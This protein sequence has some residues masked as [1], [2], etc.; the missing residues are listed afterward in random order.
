M[1]LKG[2]ILPDGEI[3][4][5]GGKRHDTIVIEYLN[6]HPEIKK[7]FD[8]SGYNLCDFMVLK[9]G[10]IKVGSNS[11]DS[12]VITYKLKKKMSKEINFYIDYY[13]QKGYRVDVIV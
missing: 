3:V 4:E 12:N 9:L 2:F 10:A 8:K 1:T 11:G 6:L 7:Q 5:Q 13:T